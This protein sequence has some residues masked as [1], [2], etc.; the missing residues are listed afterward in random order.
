MQQSTRLVAEEE[1]LDG[2]ILKL[3]RQI[4]ARGQNQPPK[5]D[6]VQQAFPS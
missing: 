6:Y 3:G 1:P 2:Y 4:T 5:S